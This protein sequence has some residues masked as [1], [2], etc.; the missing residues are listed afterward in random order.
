MPTATDHRRS[1]TQPFQFFHTTNLSPNTR[2]L[3]ALTTLKYSPPA[4][5]SSPNYTKLSN[6]SDAIN[7]LVNFVG[8]TRPQ[9]P[10]T[11]PHIIYT[12]QCQTTA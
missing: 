9:H 5:I 6:P 3:F 10:I 1:Q 4:I 8:T 11:E 2:S 12:T 7:Q